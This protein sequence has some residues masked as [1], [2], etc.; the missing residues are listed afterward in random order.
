MKQQCV[1][2]GTL[3][4]PEKGYSSWFTRMA[5]KM[6]YLKGGDDKKSLKPGRVQARSWDGSVCVCVC[7][8]VRE[9]VRVL[10]RSEGPYCKCCADVVGA[11]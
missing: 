2:A 4:G 6:E 9:G 1:C 7:T 11:P 5:M 3:T 8:C 10:P